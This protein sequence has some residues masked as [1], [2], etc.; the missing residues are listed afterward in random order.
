MSRFKLLLVFTFLL[1]VV[2]LQAAYR[3]KGRV[4]LTEQWQPKIF[5]AA[6][7]KLSDYYRASP[8]LIVSIAD[9]NANGEFVLE[10]DNL[11]AEARFYRLYMMK[12]FND[13]YDACFYIGGDD[14]NYIHVIMDN[15]TELE[16]EATSSP[17]APFED[18]RVKGNRENE[19]MKKLTTL[20]YPSFYFYQIK[21]PTELRF[22]EKKLH[23]DLK[24]FA[25]TCRSTLVA[26]AAVNHTDFDEYYEKDET[27]YK[28]FGERLNREMPSADYTTNYLRKLRYYS[29]EVVEVLPVWAAWLLGFMT[30]LIIALSLM[31]FSLKQ[32]LNLLRRSHSTKSGGMEGRLTKK[33]KEILDLILADKS[34]KE[35]AATLFIE[36]ST[37]KTHINK[38]Y[39]KLEVKSRKELFEK[40]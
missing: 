2:H 23:S 11:P 38:I 19:L 12:R 7:E 36:L 9:V 3:I 15:H 1:F 35:I 17:G 27:F 25:D 32:K 28:A 5:M 40:A 22:S 20:V 16:L 33:E 29:D 6:V 8:D 18:Y 37:V 24:N 14:H 10:G 31:L 34:N 13:D 21:F 30:M 39:S 4:N 26:L